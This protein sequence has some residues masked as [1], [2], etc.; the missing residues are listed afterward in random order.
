MN[1]PRERA[2][3]LYD[4]LISH[5]FTDAMVLVHNN[6][7]QSSHFGGSEKVSIEGY[8]VLR[9]LNYDFALDFHSFYSDNSIQEARTV[10]FHLQEL[11]KKLFK[12]GILKEGSRVLAVTDGCSKVSNECIHI[13]MIK[14][15]LSCRYS[16][17]FRFLFLFSNIVLLLLS[18]LCLL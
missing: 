6:E 8:S 14:Y 16:Q 13:L 7:I 3:G 18:T 1:D 12:D 5:D 4:I 11:F 15:Y 10:L 2:L 9:K 17:Y